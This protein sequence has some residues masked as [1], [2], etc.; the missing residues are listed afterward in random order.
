MKKMIFAVIAAVLSMAAF[1]VE[2]VPMLNVSATPGQLR[3]QVPSDFSGYV[4]K[5]YVEALNAEVQE[6]AAGKLDVIAVGPRASVVIT[7]YFDPADAITAAELRIAEARNEAYSGR[8]AFPMS[9]RLG[10]TPDG[11]PA[12]AFV[13]GYV[14][15]EGKRQHF[16]EES[17]MP[18][19]SAGNA[20]LLAN[21]VGRQ[22]YRLVRSL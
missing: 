7:Q 19:A 14:E 20:S 11:R 1:A 5:A 13:E 2:P 22:V 18:G 17:M 12:R 16:K 3:T 15:F 21:E 8:T 9:Q 6:G 4:H 10:L